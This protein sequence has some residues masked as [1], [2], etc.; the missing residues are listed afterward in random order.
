MA[1]LDNVSLPVTAPTFRRLQKG[2]LLP[3]HLGRLTTYVF[4]AVLFNLTLQFAPVPAP[5]RIWISSLFLMLAAIIF[6]SMTF[7]RLAALF[8]W[9]VQIRL[10]VPMKFVSKLSTPLLQ[11]HHYLL[12]VLLGFMPCG[13]VMAALL[14][15]SA[16]STTLQAALAMMAFSLGTIPALFVVGLSGQ[17]IKSRWPRLGHALGGLAIIS[18]SFFLFSVAGQLILEGM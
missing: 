9:L 10:P 14:A 11:K 15:S 4:L 5:A 3:Y 12:G 18:S 13:L 7:P 8:P 16:A 17:S 6:L 2:A 1:Q